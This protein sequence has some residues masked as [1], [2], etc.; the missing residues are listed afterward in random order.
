MKNTVDTNLGGAQLK[1]IVSDEIDSNGEELIRLAKSILDHPEPGFR[2]FKTSQL[3]QERFREL[4]IPFEADIAIT[5]IKGML[6]G[7]NNGPTVAILGELDSLIVAGHPNADPT[8]LAAHACGHHAQIGML[9]GVVMGLQAQN[10]LPALSGNV[11]LIAVPAEEYIEIE[12]RSELKRQGKIEFLGGKPEFIR[13]G[14]FD[15][16][17]LAMMTHTTSNPE[18]KL[19]ALSGTNN[20][21]IAKRIQFHGRAAHAGG[22]PEQGVNALNAA[23]LALSAIHTQRETFRDQDTVRVHPIITKGGTAV[24]SVPS[25]VRMETFVRGKTWEAIKNA[26]EKVDRCLRAGALAVGG[27]VTIDTLPGYL[28]LHNDP[29]LANLYKTNAVSLVGESNVFQ[30]NHRTGSTDMGDLSQLMPAIHPYAG[31]A[32]GNGHGSDYLIQNWDNA[33]ITAAKGMAFT[34]IDLLMNGAQKAQEI[35]SNHTPIIT[36][37]EYLKFMR[38]VARTEEFIEQKYI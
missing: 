5:G 9:L 37:L 28:P 1:Q 31:G 36:K 34:V 2:E 7:A 25:D 26:E 38:Q 8:T 15:D 21:L 24:S 12:F 10:V 19:L 33:I 32:T 27:T 30:I 20:G 22:S 6:R 35:K 29:H 16:V 23:M 11:A 13:L 17:D 14:K 4:G 3:V 18:E